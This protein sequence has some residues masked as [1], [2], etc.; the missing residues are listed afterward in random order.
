MEP[1]RFDGRVAIVTGAGRGIGRAHALLLAERGARVVV[2]DLGSA[3]SGDGSDAGP[4][5]Q[6][7]AAIRAA[8]GDAV[9]DG[10][11]VA[12]VDGAARLVG[13]AL[14][15]YGRVDILVNNAG[16]FSPAEFPALELSELRR[17]FD[18][19]VG[20]SFNVTRECWPHLVRAGYGRIV[21][22]TSHGILGSAPLIAYGTAKGGVFALARALA[23][24]G[25]DLGILVNSVAPVAAT[26]L[27]GGDDDGTSGQGVLDGSTPALVSPLVSLLCHESCPVSGETFLSGGRR[28]ARLFV[29]ET[30]GY[31]HPGADVT[32]EVVAEHWARIMDES[33]HYVP[34][35][36]TTWLDGNAAR[37]AAGR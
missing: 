26:R 16:I 9:A 33:A 10:S 14:D 12:S 23:V 20:G 13:R 35:D 6:V 30:E 32:P 25:K 8:G 29:A 31:V 17:Y 28:H 1:L 4:A 7:A 15:S 19:H 2:N 5:E 24:T 22:T 11:D 37:I 34:V 3:S 36:T 27:A 18:V 21:M